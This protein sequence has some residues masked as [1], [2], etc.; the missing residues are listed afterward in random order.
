MAPPQALSE[1]QALASSSHFNLKTVKGRAVLVFH[2]DPSTRIFCGR[3]TLAAAP[4]SKRRG[5]PSRR[6]CPIPANAVVNAPPDEIAREGPAGANDDAGQWMVSHVDRSEPNFPRAIWRKVPRST[7][8]RS[9]P[10]A[11]PLA[12]PAR[13][14][15]M[16]ADEMALIAL[17]LLLTRGKARALAR[18][19]GEGFLRAWIGAQG[20]RTQGRLGPEVQRLLMQGRS[21]RI[22]AG[23]EREGFDDQRP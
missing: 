7:G 23:H 4:P 15:K 2:F 12:L 16:P 11:D 20:G 1:T 22:G 10:A 6:R 5:R 21:S 3:S 17:A 19:Q 18:A 9:S 8:K 14:S 13:V